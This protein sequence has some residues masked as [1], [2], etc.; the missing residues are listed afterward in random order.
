[1]SITL[2]EVI[3]Q[4]WKYLASGNFYENIKGERNTVANLI[5]NNKI[6]LQ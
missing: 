6:H 4:T 1:M 5:N 3:L 2:C